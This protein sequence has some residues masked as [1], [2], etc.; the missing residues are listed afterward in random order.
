MVLCAEIR[1]AAFGSGWEVGWEIMMSPTFDIGV[2][3]VCWR[4]ASVQLDIRV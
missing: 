3:D 4:L 2:G 1:N